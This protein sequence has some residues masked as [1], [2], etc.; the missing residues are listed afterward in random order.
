MGDYAEKEIANQHYY[1][2]EDSLKTPEHRQI[3]STKEAEKTK[4]VMFTTP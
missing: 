2:K 4:E 1:S 3:D